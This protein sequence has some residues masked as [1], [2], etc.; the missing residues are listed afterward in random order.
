MHGGHVEAASPGPGLGAA[1]AERGCGVVATEPLVEDTVVPLD[2][3]EPAS[4]IVKR[5]STGAM[6]FG[7]IS[8]EAPIPIATRSPRG[9]KRRLE[10]GIRTSVS[11]PSGVIVARVSQK[12]L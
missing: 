1:R 5:F 11:Q 12:V 8:R 4:E 6:S 10:K 3:V 9:W 7:A 2:E